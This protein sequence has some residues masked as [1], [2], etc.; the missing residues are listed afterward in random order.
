M[1]RSRAVRLA[2][3]HGSLMPPKIIL[4]AP[5][6]LMKNEGY[7]RA[8]PMITTSRKAFRQNYWPEALGARHFTANGP[9]FERDLRARL[10]IGP[11]F[12]NK[13]TVRNDIVKWDIYPAARMFFQSYVAV[14]PA[15]LTCSRPGDAPFWICQHN[16][17]RRALEA[18]A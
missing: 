1:P 8:M 17:E 4:N 5:T 15:L 6:K 13:G 16:L 3:D 18:S 14:Q 2:K 9:G 11:S 10:T 12:G 7:A